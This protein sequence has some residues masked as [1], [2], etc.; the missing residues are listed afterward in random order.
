M[1]HECA[2]MYIQVTKIYL[3]YVMSIL[4]CL[5]MY[6]N[7]FKDQVISER[8]TSLDQKIVEGLANTFQLRV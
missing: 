6:R 1:N 3:I 5:C 8:K 7:D 2:Y 4:Q